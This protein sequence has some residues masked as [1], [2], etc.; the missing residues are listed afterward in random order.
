MTPAISYHDTDLRPRDVGLPLPSVTKARHEIAVGDVTPLMLGYR[1]NRLQDWA[2][3]KVETVDTEW[4]IVRRKDSGRLVL[5]VK[6]RE[7]EVIDSKE[8]GK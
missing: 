1:P 8:W 6:R 4:V 3:C 5:V 2:I 7:W